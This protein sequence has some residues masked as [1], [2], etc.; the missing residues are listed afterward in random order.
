M[1]HSVHK[2]HY[3]VEEARRV[4]TS[5]HALVVRMLELKQL[6]DRQGW[7]LS[8]HEYLGGRG[9]NGDGSFPPE[10][11]TIVEILKSL[12]QKGVVVKGI[13]EGILDFPHLRSNGEEV[14]LCWKV[15]EDDIGFWH[16][17]AEG[18]AGRKPLIEL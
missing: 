8:R 12:D 3:S 18:F 14:Y 1:T 9:P 13:D 6:L 5:A 15:G 10:M 11:E 16:G 2:R 17:L 7:D 4:L